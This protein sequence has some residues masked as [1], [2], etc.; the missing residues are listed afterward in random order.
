MCSATNRYVAS[1][2]VSK[3]S[4]YPNK[5][6]VAYATIGSTDPETKAGDIESGAP[7]ELFRRT[8]FAHWTS[9][10]PKTQVVPRVP[11]IQ[12]GAPPVLL[13]PLTKGVMRGSFRVSQRS[14]GTV[15]LATGGATHQRRLRSGTGGVTASIESRTDLASPRTNGSFGRCCRHL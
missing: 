4:T 6:N 2:V 9:L 7:V 11:P 10:D 15:D 14:R 3:T 12:L 8:R 5:R 13:Q 1:K